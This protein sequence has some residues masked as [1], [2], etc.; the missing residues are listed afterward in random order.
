MNFTFTKEAAAVPNFIGQCCSRIKVQI[1]EFRLFDSILWQTNRVQKKNFPF[2]LVIESNE[3]FY[4]FNAVRENVPLKWQFNIAVDF[5]RATVCSLDSTKIAHPKMQSLLDEILKLEPLL[6]MMKEDE[7]MICL[8]R[9]FAS[10]ANKFVPHLMN[11]KCENNNLIAIIT[12]L[13]NS[14]KTHELAEVTIP[15]LQNV[16]R[17]LQANKEKVPLIE[18]GLEALVCN[19]ASAYH[20]YKV[21]MI[22]DKEASDEKQ[23]KTKIDFINLINLL[24]FKSSLGICKKS[25]NNLRRII[26]RVGCQA[27]CR[28]LFG[29][30]KRMRW[31]SRLCRELLASG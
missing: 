15:S 8:T 20:H 7:K 4:S 2:E 23:V 3:F 31:S 21:P 24:K 18:R 29:A 5:I 27:S 16:V 19:L 14:T 30:I 25:C 1:D 17:L 28:V 12:I 22:I 10:V 11:E 9:L 13:I 26:T 6:G